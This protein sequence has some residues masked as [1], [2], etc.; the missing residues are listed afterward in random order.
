MEEN[1]R[2]LF[3]MVN[4]LHIKKQIVHIPRT[5]QLSCWKTITFNS[6][7]SPTPFNSNVHNLHK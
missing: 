5:E 6:F 7:P 1:T 3:S 4:S 2:Q